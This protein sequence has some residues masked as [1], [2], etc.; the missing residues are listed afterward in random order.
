MRRL[1]LNISDPNESP[2]TLCDEDFYITSIVGKTALV[3]NDLEMIPIT[4]IK[5]LFYYYTR[6]KGDPQTLDLHKSDLSL[7][8]IAD[9]KSSSPISTYKN[10]DT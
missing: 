7:D 10:F 4:R 2:V 5:T 8:V 6:N 3:N 9:D 1:T